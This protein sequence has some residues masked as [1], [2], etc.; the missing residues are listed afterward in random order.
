MFQYD[1]LA[2]ARIRD[3]LR[4]AEM[5]RLRRIAVEAR[6]SHPTKPEHKLGAVGRRP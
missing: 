3:L 1:L 6:G 5:A 2:R 4:D